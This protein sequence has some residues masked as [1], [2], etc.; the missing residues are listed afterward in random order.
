MPE[1]FN[2]GLALLSLGVTLSEDVAESLSECNPLIYFLSTLY[3]VK[4]RWCFE[5]RKVVYKSVRGGLK[6][7]LENAMRHL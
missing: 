4:V 5:T 2:L 6:F 7:H 1:R 3:A